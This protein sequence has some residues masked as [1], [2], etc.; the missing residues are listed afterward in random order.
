[1]ASTMAAFLFLFISFLL[2]FSTRIFKHTIVLMTKLY[3]E[4][5]RRR[6]CSFFHHRTLVFLFSCYTGS[7]YVGF[8]LF[9]TIEI[10]INVYWQFFHLPALPVCSFRDGSLFLSLPLSLGRVCINDQTNSIVHN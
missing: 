3:S 4:P 9:S 7:S 6:R 8:F 10:V 5:R 1:M 2:S